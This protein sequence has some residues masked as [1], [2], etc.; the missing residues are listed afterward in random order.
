MHTRAVLV[1]VAF[2]LDFVA[3]REATNIDAVFAHHACDDTP[4]LK[5]TDVCDTAALDELSCRRCQALV[6]MIGHEGGPAQA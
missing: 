3:S 1:T 2:A 6:K 4:A 5:N